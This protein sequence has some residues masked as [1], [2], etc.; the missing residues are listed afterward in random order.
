MIDE[1]CPEWGLLRRA[2][3]PLKTIEDELR[4]ELEETYEGDGVY[5]FLSLFRETQP[6]EPL[7]DELESWRS[8]AK[9]DVRAYYPFRA[10]V[11]APVAL[12]SLEINKG[13]VTN[14]CLC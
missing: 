11:A 6:L 3:Q 7:E 13:V 12:R 9:L 4:F 10:I 14:Q 1:L 8:S 5:T 2:R